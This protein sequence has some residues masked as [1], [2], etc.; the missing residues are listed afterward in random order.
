MDG[1]CPYSPE[2]E[3][4]RKK[5]LCGPAT[6]E[7]K[8]MHMR[9]RSFRQGGNETEPPSKGGLSRSG[10][11]FGMGSRGGSLTRMASSRDMVVDAF[12]SEREE[13]DML[14]EF[15]GE[16]AD[17]NEQF[18]YRGARAIGSRRNVDGKDVALP[19]AKAKKGTTGYGGVTSH[20]EAVMMAGGKW[21]NLELYGQKAPPP[22]MPELEPPMMPVMPPMMANPQEPVRVM[23]Q[24]GMSVYDDGNVFVGGPS[25]SKKE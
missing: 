14:K 24:I 6:E 2:P 17:R 23:S 10:S 9:T 1:G 13:R 22:P 8:M 19:R 12:Y 25:G 11:V 20:R 18:E 7:E 3:V 21:G 4:Y 5:S 16:M 15:Y